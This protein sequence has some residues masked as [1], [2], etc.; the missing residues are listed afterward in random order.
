MHVVSL[1]VVKIT[2]DKERIYNLKNTSKEQYIY[3]AVLCRDLLLSSCQFSV[4]GTDSGFGTA[5]HLA[6]RH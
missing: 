1:L 6:C 2:Y 4:Q 5:Q 3:F